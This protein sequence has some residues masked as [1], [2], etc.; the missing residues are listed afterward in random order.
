ML[1]LDETKKH[2]ISTFLNN[3][4]I[5]F[6]HDQKASEY[7]TLAVGGIISLLI[8]P[9][10][11]EELQALL[12]FLKQLEMEYFV[13]GAGSNLIISDGVIGVPL[14]KLGRGFRCYDKV[15]DKEKNPKK[16]LFEVGAAMPLMSLLK[17]LSECGYRS[18]EFA[19][20]IPA[21][22]GGAVRI[23]AGAHGHE[24][25]EVIKEVSYVSKDGEI[26]VVGAEKIQFSYRQSSIEKSAVI[27]SAKLELDVGDPDIINRKRR[28]CLDYRK[29]TQPLTL[30]S[31]G[32]VFKNPSPD[33]T[34]GMLIESAGLKGF[35][36]GE[37]K[38]SEL[39][40]NWIVNANKKASASE[41]LELI[42]V[43]KE[44]VKKHC[45]VELEEEVFFIE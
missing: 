40:A 9:N 37:A 20:G 36:L 27:F 32:S 1:H 15:A 26:R 44:K 30:P 10:T 19:G 31:F 7:T 12:L 42:R 45:G 35:S 8:E 17:G 38:V 22:L 21:S 16:V 28:E 24:L 39:H 5:K 41:V 29:E 4:R 6:R 11:K 33:K 43:I 18:L 2:L 25:S 23:N 34:A 13:L 14:I 3:N